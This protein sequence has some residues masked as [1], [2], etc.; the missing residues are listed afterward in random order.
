MSR[1]K[2]NRLKSR[3]KSAYLAWLACGN[4]LDCG[5]H[6][7]R[8]I[9]PS[10]FAAIE[11]RCQKYAKLLREMGEQVPPVPGESNFR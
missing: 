8:H 11:R 10:E 3:L 6:M 4:D 2:V 1:C 5:L 7:A 9:R